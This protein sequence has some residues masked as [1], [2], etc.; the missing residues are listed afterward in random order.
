MNELTFPFLEE[1]DEEVE[2]GGGDGGGDGD[3]VRGDDKVLG[4]I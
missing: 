1:D 3:S 4:A 2:D